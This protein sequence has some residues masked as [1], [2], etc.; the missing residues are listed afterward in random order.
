MMTKVCNMDCFVIFTWRILHPLVNGYMEEI[1][2]A[3]LSYKQHSK[4]SIL[5]QALK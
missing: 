2:Y 5:V 1:N 4:H 3:M